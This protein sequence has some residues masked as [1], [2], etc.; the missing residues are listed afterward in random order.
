M[1]LFRSEMTVL[2]ST[3]ILSDADEISDELLLLHQGKIV[4]SGSMEQLRKKYQTTKIELRLDDDSEKYMNQI[5]QLTTVK[6]VDVKRDT[7]HVSVTNIEKA[8]EEILSNAINKNWP[9]ASFVV[10]RASLEEMFMKVVQS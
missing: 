7:I 8:R 2:I 4:E 9:L 3:H 10:N 5:Q 1:T 6:S